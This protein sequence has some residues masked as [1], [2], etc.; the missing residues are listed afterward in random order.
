M[1][2]LSM[3]EQISNLNYS[4]PDLVTTNE[5][6]NEFMNDLQTQGPG[7]VSIAV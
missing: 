3:C 2:Y 5:L 6:V 4:N 1:S 7:F